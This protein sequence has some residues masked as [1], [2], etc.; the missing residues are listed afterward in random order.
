M[1]PDS[2]TDNGAGN[3]AARKAIQSTDS[4]TI[5]SAE[6]LSKEKTMQISDKPG[7]RLK[8]NPP[9][10]RSG[11]ASMLGIA[12]VG[13]LVVVLILVGL[14]GKGGDGGI[15]SVIGGEKTAEESQIADRDLP[16]N[17][18]SSGYL[19]SPPGDFGS[20]K[21][22][23]GFELPKLMATRH[24]EAGVNQ[25]ISWQDGFAVMVVGVDRDYRPISEFS[26]KRIS[27][28]GDELVRVNFLIGNASLYNMPIGYNDLS[29]YAKLADGSTLESE[30]IDEDTYS[31]RNGQVLGGKQTRKISMHYR[32]KRGSSFSIVRSKQF[33]QD[34]AQE[35]KGEERNPKLSL[36]I[37]L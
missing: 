24:D 35:D 8:F 28:S 29:L 2:N 18:N 22:N 25:Q 14:L 15:G 6:R 16:D 5:N 7:R 21:L 10:S 31:T 32:V 33:T 1:K 20:S 19:Q 13:L 3:E 4:R 23:L 17:N 9:K 11:K 36:T 12:L 34:Q 37:N 26:Y 30:R 27:Q